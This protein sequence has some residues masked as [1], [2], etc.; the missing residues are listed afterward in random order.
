MRAGLSHYSDLLPVPPELLNGG[1]INDWQSG[2]EQ[3]EG[4]V[5]QFNGAHAV[6][7]SAPADRSTF[8]PTQGFPD[9][10]LWDVTSHTEKPWPQ[11]DTPAGRFAYLP[12]EEPPGRFDQ[13]IGA[14]SDAFS[15]LDLYS[16]LREV[17]NFSCP[18]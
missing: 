12:S 14:A 2:V 16:F 1:Q 4:F 17:T 18:G 3:G 7:D 10:A 5:D 6:L 15:F 13:A 11:P 8:I 9:S